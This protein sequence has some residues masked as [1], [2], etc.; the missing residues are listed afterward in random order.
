MTEIAATSEAEIVDAVR[1]ARAWKSPFAIMGAGTKRSLGRP[2]KASGQV[3]VLSSLRGI[4]TY[5][6]AELIITAKAGT[7]VTEIVDALASKSQRLGFD[8]PDWNGLLGASGE[9]T[10]AGVVSA[11]AAGPAR[12]RYGAARDQLLG[13]R[14]VNG[15]GEAFKAGGG[16]VKNVTGFDLPKLVCGAFGTLCVL[17]ELTLRVYPKPERSLVLALRDISMGEALSLL[18]EIWSSALEPSGLAYVPGDVR[19]PA[20]GETGRGAVLFRVEGTEAP[21]REKASMLRAVLKGRDAEALAA[22]DETFNDVGNGFGFQASDLDLWRVFVPPS[23]AE[24]A[25]AAA[26]PSLWI[27]DWAGALLWLA[28]DPADARAAERIAAAIKATGGHAQLLRAS[29]EKRAKTFLLPAIDPEHL[30]L[31]RAVK[32][33]FDPLGL[34]NPGRVYEGI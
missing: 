13:F 16:V 34:F 23:E 7:P 20:L 31:T 4:I 19:L 18:R 1:A 21:L 33:A 2:Q 28:F 6:P 10:L 8:P 17:T 5:D 22:G 3:L 15:F 9:A 32:A 27:A 12:L 30:A 25:L 14:A 11:D 24:R 26:E 29:D